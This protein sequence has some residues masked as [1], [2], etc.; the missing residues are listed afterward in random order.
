MTA[1]DRRLLSLVFLCFGVL[2]NFGNLSAPA[3]A[4]VLIS[5]ALGIHS[6]SSKPWG[7]PLPRAATIALLLGLGASTLL[8]TDRVVQPVFVGT[9]A[10]LAAAS[11]VA[12]GVA[13]NITWGSAPIDVFQFQQ[14]AAQAVLHGQNPYGPVVRSPELVPRESSPGCT[15]TSRTGRFC[16]S[17]R[18]R[19]ASLVT[20]VCCTSSLRSSPPRRC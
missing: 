3:L 11:S 4:C 16:L 13:A 7:P 2:H 17:W 1:S 5:V 15:C 18:R 6:F 19:S 9:F 8:Y 20:F 12:I 10:I 14:S